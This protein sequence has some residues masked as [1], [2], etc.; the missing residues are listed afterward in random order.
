M[1]EKYRRP[2][3]E[4]Y[5]FYVLLCGGIII[6]LGGIYLSLNNKTTKGLLPAQPPFS[7]EDAEQSI[8]GPG[9]LFIGLAMLLLAAMM[10]I[11][12]TYRKE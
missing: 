11:R 3:T 2:K 4:R 10:M 5:F 8:N 1:E 12:K 6:T 7:Y 9:I